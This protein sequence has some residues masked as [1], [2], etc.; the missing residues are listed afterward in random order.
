MSL[1]LIDIYNDLQKVA[2]PQ[3]GKE[4]LYDRFMDDFHQ[5]ALRELDYQAA[6]R[7]LESQEPESVFLQD[8]DGDGTPDYLDADP[9]DPAVQ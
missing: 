9:N 3:L 5:A 2:I 7:R 4:T 8:S 1:H 6:V